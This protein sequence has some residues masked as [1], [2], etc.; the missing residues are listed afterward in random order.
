[1]LTFSM[2]LL[3][4]L[5]ITQSY[6]RW[7]EGRVLLGKIIEVNRLFL[8]QTLLWLP[9]LTRPLL[10][11][12][13]VR[14]TIAS[15]YVMKGHI[16]QG[17]PKDSDLPDVLLPHELAYLAT[18]VNRPLGISHVWTWILQESGMHPQLQAQLQLLVGEYE[19]R[20]SGCERILRTAMPAEFR[21]LTSRFLML[22]LFFAPIVLWPAAGWGTI[23]LAPFLAFLLIGVENSGVQI[24]Q[25]FNT[26]PLEAMCAN[27]KRD[28]REMEGRYMDT[29]A[30]ALQYLP[31]PPQ[32]QQQQQLPRKQF[33]N[34]T[35]SYSS[36]AS[37]SMANLLGNS[38]TSTGQSS[39]YSFPNVNEQ[40]RNYSCGN[41][42]ELWQS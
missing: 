37:G 42:A 4:V 39:H 25:V 10:G 38:S 17:G 13:A 22:Y 3:L 19:R 18:W 11:P 30:E 8:Q 6:N 24:E 31:Q 34:H 35:Q 32:Q 5:K 36:M 14:W 20:V 12:I 15:M 26:M 1:M 33:G 27:I 7:W 23:L 21:R 29:V 41:T 2:S 40:Y 16:S 9:P 28:C